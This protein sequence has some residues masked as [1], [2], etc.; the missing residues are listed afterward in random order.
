MTHSS[1]TMIAPTQLDMQASVMIDAIVAEFRN[2]ANTILTKSAS[3]AQAQHGN[4]QSCATMLAPKALNRQ[5]FEDYLAI[6]GWKVA[7]MDTCFM[8]LCKH[9]ASDKIVAFATCP[10][11]GVESRYFDNFVN[12]LCIA[13]KADKTTLLT[14]FTA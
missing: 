8:Y 5:A 7:S 10:V 12:M 2:A 1:A 6:N 9:D 11:E 4:A 13:D 14:K 3:M